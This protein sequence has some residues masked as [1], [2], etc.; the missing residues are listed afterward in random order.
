MDADTLQKHNAS[1]YSIERDQRTR[2]IE[3]FNAYHDFEVTANFTSLSRAKTALQFLRV[4]SK[5]MREGSYASGEYEPFTFPNDTNVTKILNA[6]GL[7]LRDGQ[8]R[9]LRVDLGAVRLWLMFSES[10]ESPSATRK[11][12]EYATQ[13]R[14]AALRLITLL[15]KPVA[16]LEALDIEWTRLFPVVG[17]SPDGED[18]EARADRIYR[19]PKIPHF[20]FSNLLG[21]LEDLQTE[22]ETIL[23]ES[24]EAPVVWG[25]VSPNCYTINVH[26]TAIFKRC[27]GEDAGHGN[28][29]PFPRFA[30]AALTELGRK[31]SPETV[32]AEMTLFKKVKKT[33][34]SRRKKI[35]T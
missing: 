16:D 14:A 1:I 24:N 18:P 9:P 31:C 27:F 23:F 15:N 8:D 21:E 5:S 6:T 19:S 4:F 33:G 12:V 26:L 13:V 35:N 20:K 29:G 34:K 7:P 2:A 32:A 22:V 30:V 3:F 11:R 25:T 28:V 10:L 17:T